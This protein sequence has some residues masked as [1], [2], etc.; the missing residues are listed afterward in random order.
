MFQVSKLILKENPD[1]EKPMQSTLRDKLN[2]KKNEKKR[3]KMF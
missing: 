2:K 1:L 3:K